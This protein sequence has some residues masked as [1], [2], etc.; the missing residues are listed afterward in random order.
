M[1]EAEKRRA[2]EIEDMKWL[3]SDSRG[4]R[5]LRRMLDTAG[6]YRSTFAGEDTHLAA[7][8]E[9]RRNFAL[10]LTDEIITIA[11]DKWADILQGK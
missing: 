5:V 4:R 2:A 3:L 6:L 11:P 9:G 8:N 1:T 7:F 10:F